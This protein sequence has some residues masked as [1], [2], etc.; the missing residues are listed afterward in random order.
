MR[1][2]LGVAHGAEVGRTQ[3]AKSSYTYLGVSD[4]A[5]E[6]AFS[7]SNLLENDQTLP[8]LAC[9]VRHFLVLPEEEK[10]RESAKVRQL[11]ER[12]YSSSSDR[13]LKTEETES[14]GVLWYCAIKGY[15]S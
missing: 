8:S 9:V 6:K 14:S 3:H 12:T 13:S 7:P 4:Q 11:D 10:S 1:V 15:F 5:L 2:E